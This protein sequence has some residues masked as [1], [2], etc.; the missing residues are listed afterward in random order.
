MIDLFDYCVLYIILFFYLQLM[1]CAFTIDCIF[2]ISNVCIEKC[3]YNLS[4]FV[5]DVAE[6]IFNIGMFHCIL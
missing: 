1:T 3:V 4:P 2:H 6:I 5:D